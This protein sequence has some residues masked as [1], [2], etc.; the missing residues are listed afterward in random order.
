MSIYKIDGTSLDGAYDKNGNSLSVVYNTAGKVIYPPIN[1]TLKIM[2]YNVGGWYDGKGTNVPADKDDAYYNLQYG[3]LHNND[4]D[5]LFVN[6][7]W[8]QFSQKPRTALS[9]LQ[10]IFPYIY[11]VPYSYNGRK[12]FGRAFC[13]KFP[14]SGYQNHVYDGEEPRYYDTIITTVDG[15]P[16]TLCVTHLGLSSDVRKPQAAE[17]LA[18]AKTIKT[19]LIIAG[20]MNTASSRAPAGTDYWNVLVPFKEAGY[21]LANCGD[22]G[23]LI[24]YRDLVY[25][26]GALDNIIF[27]RSFDITAV[28]VDTTKETDQLDEHID[29]E[30]LIATVTI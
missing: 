22:F 25:G 5:I 28:T 20:D 19:P 23:R 17:L 1:R 26:N 15:V 30:P 16:I 14:L 13:S 8:A 2:T 11:D 3:M 6:E 18:F 10:G 4:P 9:V 29:H 7:Y 27:S 21:K 24:T 12:S